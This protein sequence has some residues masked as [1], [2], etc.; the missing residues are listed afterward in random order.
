MGQ[1]GRR[2]DG[3]SLI[4]FGRAKRVLRKGSHTFQLYS[5]KVHIILYFHNIPE[6]FSNLKRLLTKEAGGTS[7]RSSPSV[8]AKKKRGNLAATDSWLCGDTLS[9]HKKVFPLEVKV[10]NGRFF[11]LYGLPPRKT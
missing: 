5:V 9:Q 10:M 6:A 2:P 1:G 7:K 8:T 3:P 4:F 11:I